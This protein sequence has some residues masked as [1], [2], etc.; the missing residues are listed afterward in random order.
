MALTTLSSVKTHLGISDSAEDAALT[1]LLAQ[2]D[3]VIKAELGANIEQAAYTE[4]YSGDGGR[5]LV[6]RQR[7]VQS[8]ASIHVDNRGFFGEAAGAFGAESLLVAGEDYALQRD[9]GSDTE[10]SQSGIV[11][12]LGNNWPAAPARYRGLLAQGARRGIGN[13]KVVYTAGY[14]TPPADLE[15]AANNLVAILRRTAASGA[16]VRS[17]R[18]DYYS[19][20]LASDASAARQLGGIRATLARY[21]RW[22][23]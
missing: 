14:A 18:L 23:W 7:P 9:H 1:Q 20:T 10:Q 22:E 12:R 11:L 3:A 13:I 8:I 16:P 4:F 15:L 19:Y 21:K 17:E 2:A 5:A 6:L